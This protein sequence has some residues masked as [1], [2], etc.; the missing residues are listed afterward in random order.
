MRGLLLRIL[1]LCCW[2][3]LLP[4]AYAAA[5]EQVTLQ[6]KWKHQFQFAG[7]Y[8]AQEKGYYRDAGFKVDIREAQAGLDPV[9]AVL[10]NDAQFGIG[11]SELLLDYAHGK[12]IVALAVIVQ[13]S[14]LVLLARANKVRTIADLAGKRVMRLASEREL[15]ALLH[16]SGLGDDKIIPVDHSFDPGALIRGEVDAV[17]GYS[18]DETYLLDRAGFRYT[19]F[20]PRSAGIDFYGDTLFTSATLAQQQPARVAAFRDASLRGWRYAMAHPEE[21]ADLILARYSTRHAREHLLFEAA[22]LRKLMLPDLVEIGYMSPERWQGIGDVYTELGLAD[23]SVDVSG[24][25]AH[26]DKGMPMWLRPVLYGG[27]GVTL[28]AGL[29]AWRFAAL[30]RRLREEMQARQVTT[31]ALRASEQKFRMLMEAAPFPVVISYV[32]GNRL[33]YVNR[34]CCE[35]FRTDASVAIGEAAHD[36]WVN[37]AAREK[38]VRAIHTDGFVRDQEIEL[39]TSDGERF[40]AYIS[41]QLIHFE[42]KPAIFSSFNDITLRKRYESQLQSANRALSDQ[43]A[44]I[45]NL[46]AKLSEQVVRDSLSGLHNRRYFDETCPRELARAQREGYPLALML[47]DIDHFKQVNDTFGH[48]A[49]D[50]VL[51]SLATL[52]EQ[53]ARASDV[54]CRYGGEEF[55]LLMPDMALETA[56]ARA[57]AL[58][59][60]FE[61]E[62]VRYGQFDICTTLSIG[63]SC[64]PD[65]GA[66]ADL[67]IEAA[68]KALYAAKHAGRNR[69]LAAEVVT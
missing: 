38:F 39:K 62:A 15:E 52:L 3:A 31:D 30:A 11:T 59:R 8:A 55:V 44:E 63:V 4:A 21:I 45:R 50:E 47:I 48:P 12:P 2:P 10:R 1:L 35:R 40:W 18:T 16:R 32:E 36:Y 27:L 53:H 7:Y 60:S 5:L 46:Q 37:P 54:V 41:A 42:G 51:V 64:F 49:G 13:H 29:L 61:R 9:D 26:D 23:R 14:P 67:L 66:R 22:E 65:H 43:L 6:L 57:D 68:D 28:M 69:V 25:L 19:L 33:A 34:L 20:S 58:R 17:S 56:L 24:F